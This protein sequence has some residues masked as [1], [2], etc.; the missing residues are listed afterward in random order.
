MCRFIV[1]K[2]AEPIQVSHLVTRPRHSITNQAFE[3]KLRFP[4][5]RPMNADGF[6][7]GWYDPVLAEVPVA[8]DS[9]PAAA[10]GPVP[11][12]P[13]PSLPS[14]LRT[15]TPAPAPSPPSVPIDG[16]VIP[17]E[18]E[19]EEM[20]EEDTRAR[21]V[22]KLREEERE[23]EIEKPCIFKSISPAWSNANL[24][25]LAEKLRSHLVFAHVRASTMAGAPSE[26]NCHP[27][28]F[29]RLMWM[30]NG[31]ISDFPKIKRALQAS[32]PEELFLYPSGYTDS[33]WAF[34]VFLSMLKDPHARSFTHAELREAM[35]KTIRFINKLC[36][37]AGVSGPSLM[38]Y[39]VTDGH[40]VVA[41]R[42]ISSRTQEAS[43]LFFSSGTSFDEYEPN[44]GLYRMTKA[45]KRERIIM[46][47]SEPLTFERADWVEVKTNMMIVITP[48]M[49]L[50]QIPIIDEYWVAPQDPA[51]HA[52][53]PDL[54]IQLGF[55]HG[56]AYDNVAATA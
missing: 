49:N 48:K 2:G 40:T 29:D 46:I 41:T 33:E 55:G 7:I 45:D 20:A 34:M 4:S 39:V 50:L 8:S 11:P 30:H 24:T 23:H 52:R 10:P 38:N 44:A 13:I 56:F 31:E 42:Y 1:Y 54:A 47:A 17:P 51:S 3:S 14:M 18:S 26:D 36:K 43:S 21:E 6:G 15:G 19:A 9:A 53:S 12:T 35:M 37:D 22:A 5:S 28:I 16:A 32:L 25:R 27:W